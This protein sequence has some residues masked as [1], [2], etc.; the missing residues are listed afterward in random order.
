MWGG[1]S[2]LLKDFDGFAWLIGWYAWVGGIIESVG[3]AFG[4]LKEFILIIN[5]NTLQLR[6]RRFCR[7]SSL[8]AVCDA[9]I[10]RITGC[11]SSLRI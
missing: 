9:P 6:D 8:Q 2:G 5:K 11:V 3:R 7:N 4:A 1:V 10:A